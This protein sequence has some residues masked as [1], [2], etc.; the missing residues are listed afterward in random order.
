MASALALR[1]LESHS[2]PLYI[3]SELKQMSI[4]VAQPP[5]AAFFLSDPSQIRNIRSKLFGFTVETLRLHQMR[6]EPK[7]YSEYASPRNMNT[8]SA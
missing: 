7:P 8:K 1:A 5:R 6:G 2:V 3:I 4:K